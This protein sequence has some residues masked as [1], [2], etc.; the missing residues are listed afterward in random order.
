MKEQ[1][2]KED[3]HPEQVRSVKKGEPVTLSKDEYERLKEAFA[4]KEEYWDR[5]LR[6]QAEFENIKKRLERERNEFTKYANEALILEL[7][8]VLDD[9][10][11]LVFLAEKHKED[12]DS[13]LKGVEIILSHLYEL[14]KKHSVK[15]IETKG[16]KFDPLFHEALMTAETDGSDENKIVEELQKGYLLDNKVIRTA[17]VKVAKKPETRVQKPEEEK[18]EKT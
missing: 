7:L 18:E 5:L 16:Q 1:D 8:T 6:Q 13:F 3:V 11:R 15:P 17:K 4:Q 14:L 9:L 10:E 12:F 2:H